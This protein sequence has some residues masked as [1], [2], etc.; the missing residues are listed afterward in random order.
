MGL[1]VGNKGDLED[2]EFD[3][4]KSMD[5]SNIGPVYRFYIERI[6]FGARICVAKSKEEALKRLYPEE[7]QQ[8]E[9][10]EADISQMPLSTIIP[11]KGHL[12]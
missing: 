9:R 8:Q 10:R 2:F 12:W 7:D 3:L 11:V 4:D 6:P 1:I 5:Y